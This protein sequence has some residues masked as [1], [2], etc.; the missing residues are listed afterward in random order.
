[1]SDGAWEA[2]NEWVEVQWVERLREGNSHQFFK[3]QPRRANAC[4][5]WHKR[6]LSNSSIF[7]KIRNW[8]GNKHNTCWK[9]KENTLLKK[10]QQWNESINDWNETI[11]R[12]LNK[13]TN[14]WTSWMTLVSRSSSLSSSSS[15]SS[16]LL[17]HRIHFLFVLLSIYLSRTILNN[18]QE[19][20]VCVRRSWSTLTFVPFEPP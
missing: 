1:M 10:I 5:W 7:K 12:R 6:Q 14:Y 18:I 3:N 9:K 8:V 4:I 15:S 20:V 17:K 13:N 11:W 19:Y 16:S 2:M